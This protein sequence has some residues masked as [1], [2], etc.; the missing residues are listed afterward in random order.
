[1]TV[2]TFSLRVDGAAPGQFT[3][4]DWLEA[5]VQRV[6]GLIWDAKAAQSDVAALGLVVGNQGAALETAK[7]DQ[8]RRDSVGQTFLVTSL[9]NTDGAA[10]AGTVSTLQL[11]VTPTTVAMY[12]FSPNFVNT[13]KNPTLKIGADTFEIRRGNGGDVMPGELVAARPVLLRRAGTQ[14]RLMT[15]VSPVDV[16]AKPVTADALTINKGAN[17]PLRAVTRGGVLSSVRPFIN[18]VLLDAK[19]KGA[20]PGKFYRLEYYGNGNP[21]YKWGARITEYDAATYAADGSTGTM[22]INYNVQDGPPDGEGIGVKTYKSDVRPGFEVTLTVDRTVV[23]GSAIQMLQGDPAINSYSWIIDPTRYD[24]TVPPVVGSSAGAVGVTMTAGGDLTAEWQTG[25]RWYR[26]ALGPN[27]FNGLPNIKSVSVAPDVSGVPGA[28]TA[29]A[30]GS[31]D[32]LPPLTFRAVENGDAGAMVYTG[33]NHGSNGDASGQQTAVNR[34]WRCLVDG[35][36]RPWVAFEGKADRVDLTIVNDLLAYNTITLGRYALRQVLSLSITPG[37]IAVEA[38]H[39]PLEAIELRVDNGLQIVT[40]GFQSE[41]TVLGGNPAASGAFQ[42][43]TDSGPKSDYPNAWAVMF[44]NAAGDQMAVWM[45]RGYAAGDGAMVAPDRA[46]IRPNTG[47]SSTK[48]Y[49]AVAAGMNTALAAGQSYKWRGGYQ[50]GKAGRPSPFV[51]GFDLMRAGRAHDVMAL[52][53]ASWIVA[54]PF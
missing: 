14:L 42:A 11:G 28:W 3:M 12:Q 44:R 24:Y 5:E 15:A 43:M 21:T 51:A 9:T 35:Q 25:G 33:G 31:T 1:M 10:Y 40:T 20:L 2:P 38:E 18:D 7:T 19:V 4:Q 52:G 32:W 41:V 29:H 6:V 39:I 23:E 53:T 48:W 16:G 37:G 27:G 17:Y 36:A 45:D 50:W 13:V 8:A 22:L 26:V 47:A 34:V 49:H 30:T 54:P 46:L